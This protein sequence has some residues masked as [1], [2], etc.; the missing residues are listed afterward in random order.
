MQNLV[1]GIQASGTMELVSICICPPI[2]FL[3]VAESRE[4]GQ[5]RQGGGRAGRLEANG[6]RER[7]V[8]LCRGQLWL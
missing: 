7:V 2:F 8:R 1:L 3:T 5:R 4:G 6:G